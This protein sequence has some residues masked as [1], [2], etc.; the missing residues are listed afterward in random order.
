[1]KGSSFAA[2]WQVTKPRLWIMLTYTSAIG[3]LAS[4]KVQPSSLYVGFLAVAATALGTSGA[5]V[6]TSYLDRDIDGIMR[7]TD[8]RPIPSGRIDPPTKALQ[9]GIVLVIASLALLIAAAKYAAAFIGFLGL[10]DNIIVY[11]AWLKRRSPLNIILGG[12]SGGAPVMVG[13]CVNA[14]PLSPI[15][16]LMAAVVV[17]WIP[18][19]IWSLA[20]RYRDDYSRAGVPM[21]PVVVSPKTAIR[22]VASTSVLMFMFSITLAFIGPFGW[23]YFAVAGVSGT[24]LLL[25]T[26]WMI[27]KPVGE[28]AFVLFKYT[29]PYLALILAAMAF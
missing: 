15:P 19:H 28:V 25:L 26:A 7:R 17:L 23:V 18:S 10:F 22:C 14:N 27:L 3:F 2:Y 16:L 29:S 4:L 21:L 1:M 8:H 12:F 6:I 20:L 13:W 11:S 5:N 9:F 24:V